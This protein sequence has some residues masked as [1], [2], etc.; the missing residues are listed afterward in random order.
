M[1]CRSH[2]LFFLFLFP[3]LAWAQAQPIKLTVTDYGFLTSLPALQPLLDDYLKTVEADLNNQQP[4]KNPDR[5]LQ[6]TANSTALA[7]RGMGTVYT[8]PLKD[9][10]LGISA[11]A[12]ADLSKNDGIKK[13]SVTG[14][15]GAGAI[16]GG[17]KLD[18]KH[19]LFFH[20]GGLS[21]SRNLP[22]VMDTKLNAE[23]TTFSVGTHLRTELV[24]PSG[25]WDGLNLNFGYEFN[26]NVL[27]F[28]DVL[29]EDLNIDLGGQAVL[30]GRLK[31]IPHYKITTETHSF[32]VELGTSITLLK[33]LT[34]FG[35]GGG[36]LN[37]GQ[38]R[39]RG[40]LRARAFSPLQCVSG[41]CTNLNLPQVEATGDL[42]IKRKVDTL[43]FRVFTGMQLNFGDFKVYVMG[44]HIPGTRV[45]GASAGL[46]IIY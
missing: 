28:E 42:N 13:S 4:I 10:S 3:T 37:F 12:A 8:A 45:W 25:I 16:M 41:V 11:G 34:I 35:G 21:H 26:R 20:I 33:A 29:N 30:Q 23:L 2:L 32:P 9:Y 44:D 17:K 18:D 22:G 43:M 1:R 7:S 24:S 40:D 5:I 39:G 38:S 19:S 14:L 36:S 31:G 6:G 27:E 15:G 46:R